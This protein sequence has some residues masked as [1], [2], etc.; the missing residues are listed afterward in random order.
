[1]PNKCLERFHFKQ[2]QTSALLT[3][4]FWYRQSSYSWHRGIRIFP[5][6]VTPEEVVCAQKRTVCIVGNKAP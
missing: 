1:M 4:P 2:S 6:P 5:L 3:D